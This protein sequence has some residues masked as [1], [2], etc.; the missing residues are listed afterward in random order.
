MLEWR[1]TLW[2]SLCQMSQLRICISF[3]LQLEHI[4]FCAKQLINCSANTANIDS[5]ISTSC[6][7]AHDSGG[8]SSSSNNKHKHKQQNC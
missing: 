5:K 2:V 3:L 8:G 7:N 1:D 6:I 4:L